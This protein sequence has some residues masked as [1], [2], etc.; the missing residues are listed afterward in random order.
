MNLSSLQRVMLHRPSC[1]SVGKV[2]PS[3][4]PPLADWLL[5]AIIAHEEPLDYTKR[6]YNLCHRCL[7]EL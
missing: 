1:S 4:K 7:V 2:D 6:T 5:P 3:Q